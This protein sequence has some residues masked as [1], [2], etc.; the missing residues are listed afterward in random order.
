L[1]EHIGNKKLSKK[2]ENLSSRDIYERDLKWLKSADIVIAEVS[3]PSL[4]VGY[5]IA[6]AEKLGKKILCLFKEQKKQ[7][8]SAM[9]AGNKKL[10]VKKYVNLKE[11]FE[12]I[13]TFLSNLK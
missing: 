5:E 9:I 7:S 1:T 13:N 2:G 3:N 6:V 11:A 10:K 8:L 12:I 4:G